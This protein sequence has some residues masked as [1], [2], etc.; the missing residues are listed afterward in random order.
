MRVVVIARDC[1]C[2]TSALVRPA[3][4]KCSNS[5]SCCCGAKTMATP[6]DATCGIC[7]GTLSGETTFAH[8]CGHV[9]HREWLEKCEN[10]ERKLFEDG[11]LECPTCKL[12]MREC[13]DLGPS[14]P[15]QVV[16]IDDDG[17]L[18]CGHPS[19]SM[20]EIAAAEVVR[21]ER[22][23]TSLAEPAP[24][25]A[26]VTPETLTVAIPSTAVTSQ[27]A[28]TSQATNTSQAA[29]TSQGF[30]PKA[31]KSAP[32]ASNG[33]NIVCSYCQSLNAIQHCRSR[34]KRIP[35]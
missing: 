7:W 35:Q 33:N 21:P 26:E 29:D 34:L 25:A 12:T 6:T 1:L 28:D 2:A 30:E 16:A 11:E 4:L 19:A 8:L 22:S 20:S 10:N 9:L 14:E 13:R 27:A 24:E 17:A 3:Q 15:P 31:I 18:G 23:D 5:R 32:L